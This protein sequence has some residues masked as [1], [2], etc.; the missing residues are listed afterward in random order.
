[1][2]HLKRNR[3]LDRTEGGVRLQ[4]NPAMGADGAQLDFPG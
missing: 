2:Q 3:D 4:R 1:M